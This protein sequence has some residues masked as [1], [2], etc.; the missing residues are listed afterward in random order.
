MNQ[1]IINP[2]NQKEIYCT[3]SKFHADM[4]DS[5]NLDVMVR[6]S[7]EDYQKIGT[8]QSQDV[9]F[10]LSESENVQNGDG[11]TCRIPSINNSTTY[12]AEYDNGDENYFF[13]ETNL[14]RGPS[15][16]QF[17]HQ[18]PIKIMTSRPSVICKTSSNNK[19]YANQLHNHWLQQN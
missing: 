13:R 1:D 19:F 4:F 11:D 17:N 7:T 3:K 5:E 8:I 14:Q 15:L 18:S 16:S 6:Y 9:Q 2:N 10:T 12:M